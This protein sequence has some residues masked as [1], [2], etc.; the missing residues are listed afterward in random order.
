[1]Q[2]IK[3]KNN[4]LKTIESKH[5]KSELK[6]GVHL[7]TIADLSYAR[8]AQKEIMKFDGFHAIIIKYKGATGIHEQFYIID[9]KS[10]Q[11]Y[12]DKALKDANVPMEAGKAPDKKDIIGKKLY[13]AIQE[14]HHVNDDK[15]IEVDGSPMIEYQIFRTM[16]VA[17]GIIYKLTGDPLLNNGRPSD[18]FLIYINKNDGFINT[19]KDEWEA[20]DFITE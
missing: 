9:K 5:R 1:M 17:E 3:E 8:D 12:F 4:T 10:R 7:V 15:V 2:L 19:E 18:E 20:P 6:A 16:P 13:I 14:V 11:Y